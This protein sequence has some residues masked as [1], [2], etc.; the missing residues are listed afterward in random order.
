MKYLDKAQKLKLAPTV[1]SASCSRSPSGKELRT[2]SHLTWPTINKVTYYCYLCTSSVLFMISSGC[3]FYDQFCNY[4][5]GGFSFV[6]LQFQGTPAGEGHRC[7]WHVR[8][9]MILFLFLFECTLDYNLTTS[10][11]DGHK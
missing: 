10:Q 9:P 2:Q 1:F 7:A 11:V 5:K 8:V 6:S 3:C 4:M